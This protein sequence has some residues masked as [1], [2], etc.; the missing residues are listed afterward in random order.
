MLGGLKAAIRPV[1]R[2]LGLEERRRR[3]G[4]RRARFDRVLRDYIAAHPMSRAGIADENLATLA[5]DGIVV[6]PSFHERATVLE[7]RD[8]LLPMLEA[9]RRNEAP[10]RW[11]TLRYAEDGVYRLLDARHEL[12]ALGP[13]LDNAL[14]SDLAR[15]YLGAIRQSSHYVDY[16]ADLVHD[17]T[18]QLH[19]DSWQSQVK[20][21]TL[22]SDVGPANAP[23]VYW[24]GSHRDA[25]WRR[26]FDHLFWTGDEVGIAGVVPI[27]VMR[28][29][30]ASA[31]PPPVREFEFTAP[32]GSVVVADTRGIHRA[33]SLREGYRLELVQKFTAPVLV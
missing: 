25:A 33:T 30:A 23:F 11:R 7:L 31:S 4:K 24:I 3:F 20:V 16:K 26:R 29:V 8:R 19:M 28:E 10:A 18:T 15:S 14:F 1:Y 13:I 27:S 22:L 32:A 5:R 12:L 6:F 2:R 9:V 21:F 17:H